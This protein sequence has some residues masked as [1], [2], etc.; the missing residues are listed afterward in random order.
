MLRYDDD[1]FPEAWTL[2]GREA[3]AAL[4]I[5]SVADLQSAIPDLDALVVSLRLAWLGEIE[6]DR[7]LPYSRSSAFARVGTRR[8]DPQR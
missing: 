7:T 3:L 1:F 5:R 4:D 2:R 6:I 8:S